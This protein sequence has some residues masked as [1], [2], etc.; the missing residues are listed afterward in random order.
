MFYHH[1]TCFSFSIC[2]IVLIDIVRFDADYLPVCWKGKTII[3]FML[4]GYDCDTDL[5][6]SFKLPDH[7][8]AIVRAKIINPN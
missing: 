5:I 3:E 7:Y 1:N 8:E 6:L 2:Q 4:Y